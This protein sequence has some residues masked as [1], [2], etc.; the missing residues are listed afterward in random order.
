MSSAV[1]QFR[2]RGVTHVLSTDGGALLGFMLSADDQGYR[3]RYG[4][5]SF[6]TPAALLEGTA[7]ARQL[8]GSVGAGWS[9]SVDVTDARDPGDTGPG[10]TFCKKVLAEGG[11]TFKGQRLAEAVAFAFCDGL[12]LIADSARAGGGL[13]GRQVAAGM[14]VAGPRLQ[15]A[16]GFGN[17]FGKGRSFLPG[18][19]RD[20]AYDTGCSCFAYTSKTSHRF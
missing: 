3:P 1:L 12:R 11:Q 9:P 5:S 17:G 10:E 14:Q 15:S 13:T 18:A 19:V 4:L 16:F 8:V 6:L 20:L 7:P 2:G